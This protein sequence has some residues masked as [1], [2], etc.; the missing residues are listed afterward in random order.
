M[1]IAFYIDHVHTYI[2]DSFIRRVFAKLTSNQI[3]TIVSVFSSQQGFNSFAI[4]FSDFC[5]FIDSIILTFKVN[6]FMVLPYSDRPHDFWLISRK[7][8]NFLPSIISI[9]AAKQFGYTI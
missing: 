1:A 5:P 7:N 2:D 8:I 4:Y 6:T 3:E 9:D